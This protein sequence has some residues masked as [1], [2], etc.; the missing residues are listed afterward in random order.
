M[1][2]AYADINIVKETAKLI[3]LYRQGN[4][5][6]PQSEPTRVYVQT[7]NDQFGRLLWVHNNR[8]NE[9]LLGAYGLD[10]HSATIT[11][12][13]PEQIH[14]QGESRKLRL[15]YK[16]ASPVRVKVDHFT[17]H[18]DGTF[19]AKARNSKMLYSQVEHLGEP[20]GRASPPFLRVLVVS[21]KLHRYESITGEPKKPHI[22][23]R[24]APESILVMNLVF[25]GVNY[26]WN[27]RVSP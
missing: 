16:E 11:Y 1:Q 21:D 26:P 25:S 4:E 9:M 19:H 22:W 15:L 7:A 20:L 3:T 2:A 14:T 5:T 6:M 17:C 24:A 23:F 13:F 12:E 10:G 8:P 18:A 27:R